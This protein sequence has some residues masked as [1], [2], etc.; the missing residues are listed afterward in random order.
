MSEIQYKQFSAELDAALQAH[1]EWGRRILRCAILH[2]NPGNDA[3]KSDAHHLCRFGRWFNENRYIFDEM[4]ADKALSLYVNH[5]AMHD[6]IREICSNILDGKATD[7]AQLNTFETTQT[8][9]IEYISQFKT[10]SIQRASRIDALTGLPL[11]H[12]I[13]DDF[14]LLRTRARHHGNRLIVMVIDIDHFKRI[15]DQYGHAGGDQVLKELSACLKGTLRET[16]KVYRYGGEEFLVLIEAP[17]ANAEIAANRLLNAVRELSVLLDNDVVLHP[18]V[19]IG[20]ALA[21]EESL[22]E[23]MIQN[24][25]LALYSGKESGRNCFVVARGDS[26]HA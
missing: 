14:E 20:V 2:A 4:D 17:I 16:D 8:L 24:A 15:N 22:I 13:A 1:M 7:E 9:L 18:T 21:V 25:D 6:A 10:L 3:L 26:G 19:T 11:R 23:E 5:Q 12:H